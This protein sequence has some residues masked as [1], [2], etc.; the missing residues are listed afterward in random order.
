MKK[1]ICLLIA[2]IAV[3]SA[4]GVFSIAASAETATPEMNIAYC[5]LSFDNSVY[6]KY[7]VKSNVSDVKLLIW[8]SPEAEYVIG[9]EDYEITAY[10]NDDIE[11][12]SH[13]IFN[14]TELVAMQMTDVI[15]ARA[16]T[17]SGGEDY[18]SG[19]N[20][21]SIL[22]YAYNKLGKTATASEST[23]L[24]AMLTNMLS[25]GASAQEYFNYKEDRLATADWYQVKLT[26]GC[27]D[28]GCKHGLYLPGDKVTLTAPETNAD[29]KA[30]S[31]W[32]DG[33]D[34]QIATTATYELTVGRANEVYTPVYEEAV[35]P[36]DYELSADGTYYLVTGLG[37]Y[38]GTDLVIP[39][40]YNGLPMKEIGY[41]AFYGCTNLT[42]VTIGEGV[43]TIGGR[44]F[45]YCSGLTSV[46]IPD[47]V[48]TIG[49]YV[50][51][52]C[53]S[54]TSVTI[55]EGVT[56]IGYGAFWACSSLTSVTIPDS[57]T[58]I[59]DR[60]FSYCS[61]LTSITVSENNEN[62]KSING[63]LYTKD[64]TVLV[65]YAIGKTDTTFVIPDSVTT[66]GDFA[67]SDC[68]SLTS[69]TIPDSVT[70]IGSYAFSGCSSLTSV[71]IPDSV[72]TI[73]DY[74]F[75]Y[76]SSLT[77]VTIG[78]GVT[79]IGNYAFYYCR[80]LTSVVIP[81]SVTS[82]GREAFEDCSS[83]TS[84]VIGAGVTNVDY[85]AFY[86]CDSLAS[87]TVSDR[88]TVYKSIDGN[89]YTKY[90]YGATLIQ[91]AIGKT[92]T[93]F[94]IPNGVT[95]INQWAFADCKTIVRVKIHDD[96]TSIGDCAFDYCSNLNTVIIGDGVT[97]IGDFAF[98]Q[99]TSLSDVYYTGSE[100]EWADLTIGSFNSNLTNATIHYNY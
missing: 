7:A 66:I 5:N 39:E 64:G 23:E 92:E 56:T 84:V 55:G 74:A 8:T 82:I 21:Y 28:D 34:N 17:Q 36:L 98:Y 43:T 68:S 48:T 72:T 96:V 86:S 59:G 73:G 26:D 18:Y 32:E 49:S 46:T 12:A 69:V 6:I 95:S 37:D 54:L 1:R 38:T 61:G 20:K 76:C 79:T 10:Y 44:A 77:S 89:L 81:D 30:F 13:M 70:T 67:F 11:G 80:S 25:Y 83:L 88:N 75:Y 100:A 51:E 42:S 94:T 87:I 47:S 40:R 35:Q 16:Y 2:L 93:G 15:Y 50:F 22:Q 62:Y 91:Y 29:G 65:Q 4:F 58:T 60:A 63:N 90:V 31:H 27:L 33:N 24:K 53:S 19:V 78:E 45:Y 99:C 85:K 57:V 71:T 14:Y 9:T 52:R 41:K 3:I 97:N